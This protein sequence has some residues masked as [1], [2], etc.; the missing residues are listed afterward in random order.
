[1]EIFQN[2]MESLWH[3]VS[4]MS[5]LLSEDMIALLEDTL[6]QQGISFEDLDGNVEATKAIEDAMLEPLSQYVRQADC[7]GRVRCLGELHEQRGY[8]GCPQRPLRAK[9]KRGACDQ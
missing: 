2:D 1:M 8:S 4:V 9:G 3:N 6:Q 5:L 7:S